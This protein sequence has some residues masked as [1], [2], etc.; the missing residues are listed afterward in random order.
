MVTI[1]KTAQK[2]YHLMVQLFKLVVVAVN[3]IGGN[4]MALLVIIRLI[5]AIIQHMASKTSIES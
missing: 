3:S 1:W 5:V 2:H 4:V